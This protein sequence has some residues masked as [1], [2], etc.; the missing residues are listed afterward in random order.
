M[1]LKIS[2]GKNQTKYLKK[3]FTLKTN[4]VIVCR[5]NYCLKLRS[6]LI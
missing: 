2:G 1:Y 3:I 4:T 5:N 6:D